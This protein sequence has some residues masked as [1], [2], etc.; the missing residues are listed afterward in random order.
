VAAYGWLFGIAPW[1][2]AGCSV[3]GLRSGSLAGPAGQRRSA[4]RPLLAPLALLLVSTLSAQLLI[5]AGPITAQLFSTP[6]EAVAAGAFLAA[7]VI[8]RLPVFLFVAVQPSVLPRMAAHVA[9]GRVAAFRSLLVRVLRLMTLV[10]VGTFV[11]TT[12][13]G[14]VI[15][16][17]LFGPDYV[18]G[19][20]VFAVMGFSI[21]LYMIASVLGQAVLAL[22]HH[23]LVMLGWLVGLIGLIVGI[24]LASDLV[25]RALY[26][27][28]I[29]AAAAAL[30]FAILLW[31]SVQAWNPTA[32]GGAPK[33][34][35]LP[36]G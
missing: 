10:A 13:L 2:A 20:Y 24:T 9:A 36:A 6:G 19:R 29:G 26:G 4:A 32:A 16:K 22:G 15:L 5:G 33:L 18:L 17:L 12:L 30:T 8:V 28:L 35:D 25:G 31:R 14:P 34:A 3:I 27:L 23:R 1:V 11:L 7:L 21:A